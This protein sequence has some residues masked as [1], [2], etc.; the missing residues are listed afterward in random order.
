MFLIT[1]VGM[2]FEMHALFKE[3]FDSFKN[4]LDV[5]RMNVRRM[6]HFHDHILLIHSFPHFQIID[7]FLPLED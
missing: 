1:F 2:S 3:V 4:V 6:F 5:R 7:L